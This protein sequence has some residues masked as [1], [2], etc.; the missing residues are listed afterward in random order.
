M[1]PE[2]SFW[3]DYKTAALPTELRQR[4]HQITITR[5]A[6]T[7]IASRITEARRPRRSSPRRGLGRQRGCVFYQIMGEP[8]LAVYANNFEAF[9]PASAGY[10]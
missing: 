4:N 1:K 9:G 2:K 5:I 8:A 3:R 10:K 7:H 6:A